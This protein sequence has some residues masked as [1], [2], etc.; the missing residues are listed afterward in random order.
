MGINLQIRN[1]ENSIVSSLNAYS[2][3]PIEAKR[4]IL[5]GILDKITVDA[6]RVAQKELM[7]YQKEIGK[8]VDEDV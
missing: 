5:Q 8:G 7:E 4:V 3:V 1:L 6:D 2:E